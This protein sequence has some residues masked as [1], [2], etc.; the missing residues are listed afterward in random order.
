M[1]TIEYLGNI[2]NFYTLFTIGIIVAIIHDWRNQGQKPNHVFMVFVSLAL[3]LLEFLTF[4][5]GGTSFYWQ[6]GHDISELSL[7]RTICSQ[8]ITG[9]NNLVQS[10]ANFSKFMFLVFLLMA[11]GVLVW[12]IVGGMNIVGEINIGKSFTSFTEFVK[13]IVSLT[14]MLGLMVFII[15]FLETSFQFMASWISEP[16]AWV[17]VTLKILFPILSATMIGKT[18]NGV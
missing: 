13:D 3:F 9:L 16:L 15:I 10:G 1:E 8:V 12:C 7:I 4:K 17:R 18:L 2:F 5:K 11:L 14:I 6:N